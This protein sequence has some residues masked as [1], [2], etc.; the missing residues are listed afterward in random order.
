M[1][2]LEKRIRRLEDI[3]AVRRLQNVYGYY[4]D[5][6]LYEEV[7][8]LF[9]DDCEVRFLGGRFLGKEGARRLYVGR[10]RERFGGGKN[11]PQYGVLLDHIIVQ[12]VIDVD[13]DAGRAWGRFRCFLQGGRHESTPPGRAEQVRR[14]WWE[15]GVYENEYVKENGIWKIRVL[16]YRP[17]WIANYE[18]GWAQWPDP[19]VFVF[20]KTYPED[21]H[22]PDEL[23]AD[24]PRMWPEPYVVPFHYP[25]PVTGQKVP[26]P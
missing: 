9:A 23:L 18:R 7:V 17:Y 19:P 13:V 26:V 4:L 6:C 15:G 2:D 16:D 25:H 14:Q 24:P 3:E 5:K 20:T 10:F 1:E 11:G 8:D 12:D 21:P 22:G